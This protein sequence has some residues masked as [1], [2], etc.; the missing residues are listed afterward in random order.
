MKK[1][2]LGLGLMALLASVARGQTCKVSFSVVWK[3][4]LN[5]TRQGLSAS[6]LIWFQ[7]KMAKKYPD[8]CY[9]EPSAPLH[10]V[11]SISEVPGTKMIDGTEYSRP[12]FQL[13][14][15]RREGDKFVALHSFSERDCPICHPQHDV[16]ED[17][18]KWIH[19]GGI[20]DKSQGV[21]VPTSP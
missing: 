18:L 15:G 14:L 20:T 3:D 9:L 4:Q 2:A 13:S 10:L 17:A 5:N 6:D 11:F 19:S 8:V 12:T 16:M 21:E 1:L 7:K